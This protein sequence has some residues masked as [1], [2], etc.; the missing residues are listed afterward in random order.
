VEEAAAE[1]SEAADEAVVDEADSAVD[2]EPRTGVLEA[3][4]ESAATPDQEQPDEQSGGRLRRW[5]RRNR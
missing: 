4:T 1:H 5:L 2:D 3:R